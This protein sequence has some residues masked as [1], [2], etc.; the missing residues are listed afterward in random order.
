MNTHDL[1]YRNINS[2]KA[3]TS[4]I[5]DIEEQLIQSEEERE[6]AKTFIHK[7]KTR[8]NDI[9]RNST[10]ISNSTWIKLKSTINKGEMINL[11]SS[12][13]F[14]DY[15]K[16]IQHNNIL[17]DN[18]LNHDII[19]MEDINSSNISIQIEEDTEIDNLLNLNQNGYQLKKKLFNL[20]EQ[21]KNLLEYQL[22]RN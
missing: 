9:I 18:S 12:N 3:Y 11:Y 8:K 17:S 5:N 16:N 20:K 7:I 15:I 14:S 6:N 19:Q 13:F 1:I 10:R 4:I 2:S 22:N 21:N